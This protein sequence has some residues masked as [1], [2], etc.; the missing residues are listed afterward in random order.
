MPPEIIQ[1]Y[2]EVVST[3]MG[4]GQRIVFDEDSELAVLAALEALGHV[5]RRDNKALSALYCEWCPF[6]GLP[7]EVQEKGGRRR[8]PLYFEISQFIL[9]GISSQYN[10][11]GL[12]SLSE[13]L[14]RLA[15][16]H[17]AG[18]LSD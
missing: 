15:A 16:M 12:V 10:G 11:G 3:D 13:D 6:G 9:I 17:T 5:V 8:V 4:A 1:K 7:S 2:G 14:A 18:H